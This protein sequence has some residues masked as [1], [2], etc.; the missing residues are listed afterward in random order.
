MEVG[1]AKSNSGS[2]VI[3]HQ[4]EVVGSVSC[5][6]WPFVLLLLEKV[7][8]VGLLGVVGGRG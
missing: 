1:G 4:V 7:H 8:D 2:V 6:G 5:E 3:R